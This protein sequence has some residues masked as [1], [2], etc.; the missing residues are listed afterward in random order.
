MMKH[1]YSLYVVWTFI[2][3]FV[4]NE[5]SFVLIIYFKRRIFRVDIL[6]YA[7]RVNEEM[8]EA[9]ELREV[10]ALFSQGRNNLWLPELLEG[11]LLTVGLLWEIF[12]RTPIAHLTMRSN[13]IIS[14][15]C[16][17][18]ILPVFFVADNPNIVVIVWKVEY[19]SIVW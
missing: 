3:I 11:L 10:A 15:C 6:T 13:I 8:L 14:I 1:L 18:I 19:Q 7:R 17:T 4:E 2:A 16:K 9:V 12:T 5:S